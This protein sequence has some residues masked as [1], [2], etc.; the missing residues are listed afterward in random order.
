[1]YIIVIVTSG[2]ITKVISDFFKE[3]FLVFSVVL[4]EDFS[5]FLKLDIKL[6]K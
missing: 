6:I 5:I 3:I 4:G 1:M 2:G